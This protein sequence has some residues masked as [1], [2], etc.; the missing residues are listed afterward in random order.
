[1]KS[2]SVE[3]LMGVDSP[4]VLVE[5][6]CLPNPSWEKRFRDPDRL[7]ALSDMLYDAIE[8]FFKADR[9]AP[10]NNAN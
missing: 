8:L 10:G 5:I 4:A 9:P 7:A 2:D 6:G 1:M 3:V